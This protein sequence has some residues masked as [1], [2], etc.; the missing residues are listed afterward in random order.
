MK[1]RIPAIIDRTPLDDL[2]PE[3]RFPQPVNGEYELSPRQAKRVLAAASLLIDDA[4]EDN[5]PE[6]LEFAE[7]V[8]RTLNGCLVG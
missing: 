3:V 2:F 7:R 8:F 6:Y 5:R 1:R 4:R